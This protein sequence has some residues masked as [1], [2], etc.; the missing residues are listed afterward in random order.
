M[1]RRPPR[2]TLFPST[3]LFRSLGDWFVADTVNSRVRQAQPGGNLFTIAGNGNASYFGDG[4]AATKG[5]VNQPEGAAVDSLGNVYIADTLDHVVR[6]VTTNGVITTM[7]GNGSPGYSGDGGPA[8]RAHLNQPRGVALDAGGN[9]YVAD[10]GNNQVRR[11]DAQGTI[12]TVDTSGA[13]VDPRGVAVARDGTL[14]IA[15]TGNRL[16]RRVS[17]GG[18]LTTIAATGPRC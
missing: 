17:P 14:Y 18:L 15:D 11:I 16:V 4:G 9:V 13:L 8:N 10:T 12:T 3:T 5:S 6:K 1:I 7:A 2:S